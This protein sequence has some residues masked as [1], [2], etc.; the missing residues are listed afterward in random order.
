ME[1]LFDAVDHLRNRLGVFYWTLQH[2]GDW[3]GAAEQ[4]RSAIAL[5]EVNINQSRES[6]LSSLLQRWECQQL[7]SLLGTARQTLKRLGLESRKDSCE[8]STSSRC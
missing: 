3:E 2:G 8:H 6:P 7:Y 4:L 5:S 1:N